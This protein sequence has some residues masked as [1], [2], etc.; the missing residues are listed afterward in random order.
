MWLQKMFF[1][2]FFPQWWGFR[3]LCIL[4]RCSTTEL[5]PQPMLSTSKNLLR[6]NLWPNIWSILENCMH[7]WEGYIYYHLWVLYMTFNYSWFTW[8]L[9]F[10]LFCPSLKIRYWSFQ[11]LL[12]KYFCL[13]I[14][15]FLLHLFWGSVIRCRIII[16]SCYIKVFIAI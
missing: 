2:I 9:I 10:W 13:Q 11:L 3:V 6:F 1:V 4:G 16:F 12:W 14:C 7:N 15:P 8:L 5:Y